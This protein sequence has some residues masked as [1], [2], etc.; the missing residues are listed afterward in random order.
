MAILLMLVFGAIRKRRAGRARPTCYQFV[1]YMGVLLCPFRTADE[2]ELVPPLRAMIQI[3][4]KLSVCVLETLLKL[5][6]SLAKRL[7]HLKVN[8]V[9]FVVQDRSS[10]CI[11]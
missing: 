5:R 6:L 11:I 1:I 4:C 7:M 3:K 9:R 2:A 10:P 8:I